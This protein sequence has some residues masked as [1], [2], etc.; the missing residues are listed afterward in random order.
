MISK[1]EYMAL[2][3]NLNNGVIECHLCGCKGGHRTEHSTH[4]IVREPFSPDRASPVTRLFLHQFFGRSYRLDNILGKYVAVI[5]SQT[6]E[7]KAVEDGLFILQHI[8]IEDCKT[9]RDW[10]ICQE[11]SREYEDGTRPFENVLFVVPTKR[12]CP[13]HVRAPSK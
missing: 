6:A 4:K 13:E 11:C 2:A 3:I 8:I 9:D 5:E 10:R 12:L 1:L 7:E